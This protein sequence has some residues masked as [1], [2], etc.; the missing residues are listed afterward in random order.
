VFLPLAI[1]Q[2]ASY[3]NKNSIPS[4]AEYRSLLTHPEEEIIDLLSQDLEED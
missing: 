2:A 1:V 3:I 4:V